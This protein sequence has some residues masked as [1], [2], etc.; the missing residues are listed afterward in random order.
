MR[1]KYSYGVDIRKQSN[2]VPMVQVSIVPQP[3]E[4][5][6]QMSENNKRRGGN[7]I[8]TQHPSHLD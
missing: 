8:I 1:I 2:G 5:F 6:I 7:C 4:I 3:V